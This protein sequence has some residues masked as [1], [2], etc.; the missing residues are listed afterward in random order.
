MLYFQ[1]PKEVKGQISVMMCVTSCTVLSGV[2][3]AQSL[4]NLRNWLDAVITGMTACNPLVYDGN[5]NREWGMYHHILPDE[6]VN[7]TS[8]LSTGLSSWGLD[9][10]S[11]GLS[12]GKVYYLTG[13]GRG[14]ITLGHNHLGPFIN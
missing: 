10:K 13:N 7:I 2:N 11:A 1:A 6:F 5:G 9:C 12:C 14:K 8:V 3:A 4:Q